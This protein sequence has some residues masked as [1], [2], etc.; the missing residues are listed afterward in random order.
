MLFINK[1][2]LANRNENPNQNP[3]PP[4]QNNSHYLVI[5]FFIPVTMSVILAV[6]G[7]IIGVLLS[8]QSIFLVI[9]SFWIRIY[10]KISQFSFGCWIMC[11]TDMHGKWHRNRQ[12][13]LGWNQQNIQTNKVVYADVLDADLY[14]CNRFIWVDIGTIPLIQ[15]RRQMISF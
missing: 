2:N 15:T 8:S 11:W 14:T 5:S 10:I 1:S 12:Y 3:Y 9:I 13:R 7:L 6:Y 4:T